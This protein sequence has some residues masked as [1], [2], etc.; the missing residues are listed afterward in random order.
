MRSKRVTYAGLLQAA[1]VVTIVFSVVTIFDFAHRNIELFSHFR[2]QY[3]VGSLLLVVL[4]A[5][6]RKPAYSL[7][8]LGTAVL[9][10]SYVLPWYFDNTPAEGKTV[11]KLLNANVH[12]GNNEY[13]D[14]F[15]LVGEEQP[16]IIF[17][18]EFSPAWRDATQSLSNDYPFSYMEPRAGNFGIA[19]FSRIPL[20]SVTH[21]D[22]PPLGYP[23]II[24]TVTVNEVSLT[25]ID[26]HPTIPITRSL[27]DARNAQLDSLAELTGRANGAVVLIG[28]LNISP[29]CHR[30]RMLEERTGLRNTRRGFGIVPT[31]PTFMPFAMIPID[32][33]LVSDDVGVIE[34]RTGRRIGSD[35]LPLVITITI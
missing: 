32:H 20:D 13:R 15:D 5:A 7:L 30:Y 18:Q 23:T 17:L 3:L 22:S 16:D 31:W 11:I 8:L 12:A 10:A 19:M 2:L 21:I 28:D 29:W 35:H 1:A 26:T 27:Y 24:A 33:A 25:L 4:F 14:L 6:L 9:N 34:T